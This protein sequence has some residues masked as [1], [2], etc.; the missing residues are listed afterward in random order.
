M[1]LSSPP[2]TLARAGDIWGLQPAST[3]MSRSRRP[4]PWGKDARWSRPPALQQDRAGL[5]DAPER[6]AVQRRQVHA[7]RRDW[8]GVHGRGL[9]SSRGRQSASI[10]TADGAREKFSLTVG[11][12]PRTGLRRAVPVQGGLRLWLGPAPKRPST[13]TASTTTGTGTGIRNATPATRARTSSTIPVGPGSR[14]TRFK[15]SSMAVFRRGVLQ[16]TPTR[17]GA[18]RVRRRHGPRVRTRANI[19][20]TKAASASGTCSTDRRDGSGSTRRDSAGSPTWA[21]S[22]ARTRRVRGRAQRPGPESPWA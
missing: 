8:Q 2:P 10:P 5:D 20:T 19:R 6:P 3:C 4:T 14:S 16:E 15:V 13:A 11:A 9:C 21:R 18:V 1:Q 22:G 17:D 12:R 7:G